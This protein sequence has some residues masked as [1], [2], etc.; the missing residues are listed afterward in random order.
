VLKFWVLNVG[1]GDS[2]VVEFEANGQKHFGVVDSNVHDKRVP[3]LQKLQELGATQL[4]FVALTHPH[5]DH[6]RGLA[7][8]LDAYPVSNF[9]TYPL[10]SDSKRL[11]ALTVVYKE[12]AKTS[13][14]ETVISAAADLV[15]LITTAHR[16][17]Q[18]GAM[19]WVD[20]TG[21]TNQIRPIGFEGVVVHGLLPLKKYKGEYFQQ[22]DTGTFELET[23]KQNDLS[24]VLRFAY[25]GTEVVL[26]ADA[27]LRSTMDHKRELEKTNE[28]LH[29]SVVKLPHHGSRH[30]CTEG[31]IDYFFGERAKIKRRVALISADG[32]SHPAPATLKALHSRGILPYCT[33][34]AKI[35]G[36]NVRRMFVGPGIAADVAKWINAHDPNLSDATRPACQGDICVAVRPDGELTVTRQHNN[37]CAYRGDLDLLPPLS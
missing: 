21:A 9:F 29:A 37:A 15:R 22:L 23:K 8:I 10:I 30:D 28:K 34:L 13:D 1:H 18:S 5:A 33:N 12:V 17:H 3:A 14:S 20:V 6:Y 26:G 24:L 16:R 27:T 2:V 36:G 32:R 35:C 25:G 4:S 11:K 19:E 7:A 31:A